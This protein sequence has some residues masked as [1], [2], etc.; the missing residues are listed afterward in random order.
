MGCALSIA[1]LACGSGEA[2]APPTGRA[3]V[4]PDGQIVLTGCP[5]HELIDTHESYAI[6]QPT[7]SCQSSAPSCNVQT[8]QWCPGG[9]QGPILDWKCNCAGDVWSC[10]TAKQKMQYCPTLPSNPPLGDSQ[11]CAY[12]PGREQGIECGAEV[13]SC[14]VTTVQQCPGGTQGRT[15]RWV[16]GCEA[17]DLVHPDARIWS[18]ERLPSEVPTC[19]T[20]SCPII[21]SYSVN[22]LRPRVG[23]PVELRAA[24]RDDDADDLQVQW[25]TNR[26]R[27]VNPYTGNTRYTCPEA[28]TAKLTFVVSDDACEAS[29][30]VD[31]ECM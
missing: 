28:G 1:P 9:I 30:N 20:N 31:I 2:I 15:S 16:C 27:F 24:V 7:G 5:S 25:I 14:E 22:S 19:S 10:Q 17:F 4:L 12:D 23:E 21:A 11:R 26:G 6:T 3:D 18:C 29:M 8:Q 13:T